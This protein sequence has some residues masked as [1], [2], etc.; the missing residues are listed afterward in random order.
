M[1]PTWLLL[2]LLLLV[3]TLVTRAQDPPRDHASLAG[4]LLIAT[5]SMRDPRFAETVILM[6]RHDRNSAFGIVINRPV[7]ERPLAQMLEALGDK[8]AADDPAAQRRV[9]FFAGGPVQPEL[10]FVLHSTDF[11]LPDSQE[12]DGRIA[13]TANREILRALA[14]IREPGADAKEG[15][16]HSLIAFGYAGW[17]PRQLEGELAQQAWFTAP[18]DIKL[19]FEEP[20]EKV[21][22][23][24]LT[25]RTREL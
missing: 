21:W 1:R 19:V 25:R 2:S 10:G 3:P 23:I 8:P 17:G 24:A 6:V 12:I 4:Q 22:E 7:S 11:R 20:R 15:P 14:G 13:L 5:P 18:A 9:R 16:R